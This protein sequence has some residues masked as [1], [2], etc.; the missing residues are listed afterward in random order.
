[1]GQNQLKPRGLESAG[2]MLA[3]QHPLGRRQ[4]EGEWKWTGM[5]WREVKA[6]TVSVQN[7]S[8]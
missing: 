2:T 4:D 7:N 1:M 5:G 3:A 6:S 8:S